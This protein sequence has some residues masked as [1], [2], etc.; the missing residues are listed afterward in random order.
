MVE[1]VGGE[2]GGR[3][4]A[5]RSRN[6]QIA[7]LI[8]MYLRDALRVLAADLQSV[9][10]ALCDQAHT[11]LGVAMPGRTHLQHAQPILLSHHLLAHAW[12]LLRDCDRIRDL[13]R[14]LAVSPYGS[15]ALAGTS[16]GLDP[17]AVAAELG[18]TGSV[19]NS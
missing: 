13:D 18:F 10:V 4:R 11:H 17:E 14:R 2:L 15:A 19:A 12:P 1:I 7:T 9:V 6:D 8:R 16:L 5:G 3:L